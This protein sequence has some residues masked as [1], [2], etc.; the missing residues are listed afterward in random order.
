LVTWALR[1]SG[2]RSG[3]ISNFEDF[4]P[5]H[6]PATIAARRAA[7]QIG[8]SSVSRKRGMG[9]FAWS[10]ER[11]SVAQRFGVDA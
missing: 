5:V 8:P 11:V 9:G 4:L 1:A 6:P 3:G 10:P 7:E 2:V